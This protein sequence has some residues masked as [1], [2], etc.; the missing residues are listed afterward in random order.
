MPMQVISASPLHLCAEGA[1]TE[2]PVCFWNP[3]HG[4]LDAPQD[5]RWLALLPS[6]VR[7][8]GLEPRQVSACPPLK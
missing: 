8:H 3:N 5:Q 6:L 7:P 2:A 1:V 4:T